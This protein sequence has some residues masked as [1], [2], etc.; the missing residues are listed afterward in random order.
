MLNDINNASAKR[1]ASVVRELMKAHNLE[2]T[3]YV[4]SD[5]R[6]P[7]PGADF[8][9]IS[10][11]VGERFVCWDM[12]WKI[13]QQYGIPH[14]YSENGGPGGLFHSPGIIPLILEICQKIV[15]IAP[16]ATVFN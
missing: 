10:I 11:E 4:E 15:D 14:V 2:Q 3:L 7:L 1:T 9:M 13:P 16:D 6:L 12:D 5:L 8:V